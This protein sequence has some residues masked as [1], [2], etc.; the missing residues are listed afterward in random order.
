LNFPQIRKQEIPGLKPSPTQGKPALRGR[1]EYENKK[2]TKNFI[3]FYTI[4][5]KKDKYAL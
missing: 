1:R 3:L 5:H 2:E 4:I